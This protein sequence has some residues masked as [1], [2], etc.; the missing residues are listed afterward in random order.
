ME[1]RGSKVVLLLQDN[2]LI[3]KCTIVQATIQKTSFVELYHPDYSPDIA[4]SVDYL[5]LDMKKY[6]RGKNFSGDDETINTVD[7]YLNNLD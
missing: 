5:F 1:K 4:P 3:H 7:E 6:L 2:A